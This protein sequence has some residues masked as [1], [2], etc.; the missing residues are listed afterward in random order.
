MKSLGRITSNLPLSGPIPAV[1]DV[2]LQIAAEVLAFLGPNG[3]D[4]DDQMILRLGT[5]PDDGWSEIAGRNP[6]R[7]SQALQMLGAVLLEET[8]ILWLTPGKHLEYFEKKRIARPKLSCPE[9]GQGAL[10]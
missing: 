8:V 10:V 1:R 5:L 4:N 6:H 9:A 7:D 2:S 3:A